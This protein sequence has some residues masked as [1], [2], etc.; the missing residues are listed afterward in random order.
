MYIQ[1]SYTVRYG[2]EKED[3]SRWLV[4]LDGDCNEVS[5]RQDVTRHTHWPL[6][7]DWTTTADGAVMWVTA[8]L[9]DVTGSHGPAGSPK[10]RVALSTEARAT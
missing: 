10:R 5:E 4:E 2:F 7:Q 9:P 6:F 1:R 8:W 3:R